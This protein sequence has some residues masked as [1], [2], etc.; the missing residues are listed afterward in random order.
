M[1]T[2]S[3][4]ME[5]KSKTCYTQRNT[6]FWSFKTIDILRV[7]CRSIHCYYFE[8]RSPKAVYYFGGRFWGFQEKERV[9]LNV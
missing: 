2:K 1:M 7:M 8:K 9:T 5:A 3:T 6:F 4:T